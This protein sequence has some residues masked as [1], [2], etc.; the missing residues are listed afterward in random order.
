MHTQLR[1]IQ[2][3][4][5]ESFNIR[6]GETMNLHPLTRSQNSRRFL[7]CSLA[8]V[9]AFAAAPAAFHGPVSLH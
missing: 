9:L 6:S 8:A 3:Q 4:A 1:R 2:Q 7:T 5:A